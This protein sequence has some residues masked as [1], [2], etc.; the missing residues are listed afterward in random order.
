MNAF[1]CALLAAAGFYFS[2]NLGDCWPLAWL[3]PV[4]ILWLAFGETRGW[5]IFFAAWFAGALGATNVLRAYS[6]ILPPAVLALI[7]L[8]PPLL[9]AAAVMGARR[10][11]RDLGP[12][13]GVLGFAVLWTS[14]DFLISFGRDGAAMS[15][16]YSQIDAPF[17][18]QS[19]SIFGPWIVTF[20]IGA[21]SAG[22][23]I[24]LRKRSAVPVLIAVGL[25]AANAAFGVWRLHELPAGPITRVGLAADDSLIRASFVSSAGSA[26]KITDAYIAAAHKLA[27]DGATLIVFPE[28]LAQLK[29]AWRSTVVDKLA[30]ASRETR[31]TI[32]VGFD[33]S[34]NVRW[35]E[36]LVFRPSMQSPLR[37]AK[38]HF[39]PV[40]EDRYTP[41]TGNFVLPDRIGI[42]ICKDMDYPGMLRSDQRAGHPTLLAVPAWDFGED[43]FAHA[44][45]AIMRGIEGGFAVARASRDGLLT[46]TDAAGRVVAI[47]PSSSGGTVMLVGDLARGP[48]DTIYVHIGDA[49]AWLCAALAAVLYTLSFAQRKRAA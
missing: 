13:A 14:F 25:F 39:V 37:Y 34:D 6:G 47:K 30:A 44:K 36:A 5:R 11:A 41:G 42:E 46:L 40:L 1:A 23:A 8:G 28:K 26:Q 10:L 48:G 7:I 9:F 15:P 24:G 18:I 45:P 38:R 49:F 32:V 22:I 19:V 27:D 3:A 21:V 29:P 17:L 43:G 2:T 35:N 31:A 4:P 12:S 16:A 20:L 33:E